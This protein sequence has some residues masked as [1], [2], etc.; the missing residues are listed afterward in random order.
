MKIDR[1]NTPF[2]GLNF[3]IF[4][5]IIS[6]LIPHTFI[7]NLELGSTVLSFHVIF[8]GEII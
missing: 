2:S 6:G 4:E 5:L 1:V 3:L 8:F 7:S